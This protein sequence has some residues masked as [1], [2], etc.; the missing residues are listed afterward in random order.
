MFLINEGRALDHVEGIV[1]PE[2]VDPAADPLKEARRWG[3]TRLP[4]TWSPLTKA[5]V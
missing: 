5:S 3:V 2:I 1:L 4:L